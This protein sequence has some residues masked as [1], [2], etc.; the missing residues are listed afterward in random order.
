MQL[1]KMGRSK[2]HKLVVGE[3]KGAQGAERIVY[4]KAPI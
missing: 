1:P 3:K 2:E 4:L